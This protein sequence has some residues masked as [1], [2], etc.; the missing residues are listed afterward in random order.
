MMGKN[1][2]RSLSLVPYSIVGYGSS[3]LFLFFFSFVGQN[4]F[5]HYPKETNWLLKWLSASVSS[6]S[7]LGETIDTCIFVIPANKKALP[8][9]NADLR[10]NLYLKRSKATLFIK[11]FNLNYFIGKLFN[12]FHATSYNEG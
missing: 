3:T 10:F 6:M 2:F 1:L 5:T 8:V 9:D 4:S 11:I 12:R 7:I